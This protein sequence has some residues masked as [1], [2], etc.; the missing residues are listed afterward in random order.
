MT[1]VCTNQSVMK[2]WLVK[3][4]T[5]YNTNHITASLGFLYLRF[6]RLPFLYAYKIIEYERSTSSYFF[7]FIYPDFLIWKYENRVRNKITSDEGKH[8]LGIQFFV[9]KI[10]YEYKNF[11]KYNEN[12]F[13]E[14][15]YILRFIFKS[16]INIIR[17][18]IFFR[19]ISD[20]F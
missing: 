1:L 17:S 15:K 18:Y 19:L 14:K 4:I 20:L 3:Y 10:L 8:V 16:W 9:K 7:F 6:L 2:W 5:S 13:H 12:I 11:V